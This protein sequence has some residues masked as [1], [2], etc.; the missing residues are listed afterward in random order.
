MGPLLFPLALLAVRRIKPL[1]FSSD[2]LPALVGR[3]IWKEHFIFF[4]A[5]TDIINGYGST[6]TAE[7]PKRRNCPLHPSFRARR[8]SLGTV[9]TLPSSTLSSKFTGP[10]QGPL[11]VSARAPNSDQLI[12]TFSAPNCPQGWSSH[13]S[14]GSSAPA[15]LFDPLAEQ[16]PG[17]MLK[18]R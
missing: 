17:A 7:E 13:T 15:E 8:Q 2:R 1:L 12:S 16:P 9:P 14:P 4:H 10:Q 11:V 3:F 6:F 18:P 5:A